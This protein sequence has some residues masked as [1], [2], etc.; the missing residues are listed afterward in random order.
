GP[1]YYTVTCSSGETAI[2]ICNAAGTKCYASWCYT[3]ACAGYL[4]LE[5]GGIGAYCPA[6]ATGTAWK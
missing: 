1:T 2:D 6:G 5:A 3:G 4:L